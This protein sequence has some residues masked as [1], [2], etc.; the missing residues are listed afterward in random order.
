[1]P[2]RVQKPPMPWGPKQ[3]EG[4]EGP[5]SPDIPRPDTRDLL[6]KVETLQY[7]LNFQDRPALDKVKA[8]VQQV[9]DELLTGLMEGKK[10]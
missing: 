3:G 10:K 1:M 9:H 5:R 8:R 7:D 2:E 4:G 6:K